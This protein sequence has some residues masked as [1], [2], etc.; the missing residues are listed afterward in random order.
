MPNRY[1]YI[2]IL[3]M[4]LNNTTTLALTKNDEIEQQEEQKIIIHAQRE[5]VQKKLESGKKELVNKDYFSAFRSYQDA[6]RIL[7]TPTDES[8][9]SGAYGTQAS[10]VLYENTQEAQRESNLPRSVE[11][12]KKSIDVIVKRTLDST[13]LEEALHSLNQVAI[14][15]I[16]KYISLLQ[17]NDA[18]NIIKIITCKM[19]FIDYPPKDLLVKQFSTMTVKEKNTLSPIKLKKI[20]G[21]LSQAIDFYQQGKW[22]TATKNFKK[23]LQID[24]NNDAAKLG[25][26]V[27]KQE[28]N[29]ELDL[30]MHEKQ[31]EMIENLNQAWQL[32]HVNNESNYENNQA[33]LISNNTEYITQKIHK[34][35]IPKIEFIDTPLQSAL[36]QIKNEIILLDTEEQDSRKKGI[37]IV[38]ALELKK[39]NPEPK[40]TL[41]LIDTPLIDTL[42]YV[43]QQAKLQ[44]RIEP[45][46]IAIIPQNESQEILIN[47]EYRVPSNFISQ[48][49]T[50]SNIKDNNTN[51]NIKNNIEALSIKDILLSQGVTFPPGATAHFLA[52]KNILV[53]KNSAP[54]L[55]LITALIENSSTPLKQV[56]IEARFL[57]VKQSNNNER[58]ANW[59]LRSFQLGCNLNSMSNREE[60]KT[61]YQKTDCTMN[62]NDLPITLLDENTARTT[63]LSTENQLGG[64]AIN[65]HALE[66]LLFGNP[67]G[68]AIGMLGLAGVLSNTQFQFVLR[69]INQHKGV[70]LLSAPKVTVSNGKKATIRIAREF[71]YPADYSPPQIPQNQGTSVNPAIPTTPSSFKKR[72]VGVELEVEP[73]IN[74]ANN[75]IELS[76]SPQIVEFQGFVNYGNPIFSQAP[77]FLAGQTNIVT[78]TKQILLTQNNINQPIFSV[79]EVDTQVVLR[80]GQTVVLGGL[81][82][83]D[84]KKVEDKIPIISKIPIANALCRSSSE[85]KIKRNLL[86]FVTVHLLDP[87]GKHANQKNIHLDKD[88]PYK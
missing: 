56:E 71:P 19:Y 64:S 14:L 32:P 2:I 11:F 5:C 39:L 15:L 87:S 51:K 79:R 47:K 18:E 57:E 13:L 9:V 37:N 25:L 35:K 22:Y 61:S 29:N 78:A 52:S 20:E 24:P 46:A 59:L 36:E 3:F 77:I 33:P 40:I 31:N 21:I 72:N 54:N 66:A 80:D 42:K 85:Q 7:R 69:A 28:K 70:N 45:Y 4:L 53:V 1:Y 49:P 55:N 86:I 34:I 50:F 68:S 17:Y 82:R 76:L 8:E 83:E 23:A 27:I 41:S 38:L 43:T 81:M 65:A 84:I 73:I 75:N 26:S 12:P 60:S 62:D 74:A 44:M 6:V 48:F 10:G 58:G 30:N 16:L 88:T 67:A 63:S